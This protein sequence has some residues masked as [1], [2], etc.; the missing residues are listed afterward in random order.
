MQ[1]KQEQVVFLLVLALLGWW[2]YTDLSTGSARQRGARRSEAPVWTSYAVADPSIAL[3]LEGRAHMLPRDLFS[4]P[5]DTAPLPPLSL[6][7]P[8][9]ATPAQLLP[10]PTG[11]F[12][13][14]AYS[15]FLRVDVAHTPAP[16]LFA[17]PVFEAPAEEA[18][19]A[20]VVDEELLT[21]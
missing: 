3:P 20:V 18:L 9:R 17:A 13:V 8:P 6:V 5:S 7:P 2:T 21:P 19:T 1:I 12:S 15:K 11:S 16:N 4:P 10:P 14:A